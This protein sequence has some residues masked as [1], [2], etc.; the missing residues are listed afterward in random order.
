MAFG[1]F[2]FIGSI[3]LVFPLRRVFAQSPVQTENND[4]M[5][6]LNE[7]PNTRSLINLSDKLAPD[8]G[9][10]KGGVPNSSIV[11]Y[12]VN[13]DPKTAAN[14]IINDPSVKF[15][16]PMPKVYAQKTVNDP[17]YS[18]Q[19]S[20]EYTKVAGSSQSAWDLVPDLNATSGIKVAVI[21][22]GVDRTHPDLA[23][24]IDPSD[25]VVCDYN[26]TPQCYV[27]PT[28]IDDNGHGTHIAGLIAANPDNNVGIAGVGWG[29]KILSIKALKADGSGSLMN[30][31]LAAAYAVDHGIKIINLS[32]GATESSLGSNGI[33]AIQSAVD[34]VWNQGGLMIVAAGNCGAGLDPACGGVNPRMYPGASNHV[35]SVGAVT[36]S[37][38]TPSYSESGNWVTVVAPG[39]SCVQNSLENRCILSA[40]S[41]TGAACPIT[42]SP[43]GYCYEQGT[44]MASPQ[45]A[46]IAALLL[47]KDPNL[48]NS[49]ILQ[50][51]ESS[52]D[53]SVAPGA[54]QYGEVD[55]KAAL[56][57][58]EIPS[59]TPIAT[60]TWQ[61]TL[62]PVPSLTSIPS[63]TIRPTDSTTAFPSQAVSPS[64]G[65]S[66]IG[67]LCVHPCSLHEKGDTNCDGQVDVSDIEFWF[68]EFGTIP[69]ANISPNAN[70]SCTAGNIKSNYIDL[71]DF[72]VWRRNTTQYG[73]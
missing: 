60:P 29:T 47:A 72:E 64:P 70:F 26:H 55:A 10:L 20:L 40:W 33:S 38:S 68:R 42:S 27:D 23:G 31:F 5:V 71:I 15:A 16:F 59:A 45:V 8:Q 30:V 41:S 44:S 39:G 14:H 37:G 57:F 2:I 19:W 54:S 17:L 4:L 35:L 34:E 36:T 11:V 53:S 52:A 63:A 21:D 43:S 69:G 7:K 50:I 65:V 12:H 49:Q 32:L 28:G 48:T 46:G 24:K 22:T 66:P 13:S 9:Q 73:P 25:W 56:T 67:P 62:T 1:L 3:S 61:P 6:V 51:I 58:V 18:N